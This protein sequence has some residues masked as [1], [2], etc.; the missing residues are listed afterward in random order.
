VFDGPPLKQSEDLFVAWMTL[1]EGV[2]APIDAEFREIFDL[3]CEKGFRAIQDEAAF[4]FRLDPGSL[5]AFVAKLADLPGHFERAMATFLDHPD[6]WAGAM[7]FFHA[8]SLTYWRKRGGF[9]KKPAALDRASRDDL[10]RSIGTWFHET[11]GRGHHCKVEALRRDERDY[12]FAYP[13]DYG[14]QTLEWEAGQFQRR[15]HQPAFEVVFLWSE[16]DGT[17]DI[18]HAGAT[19]AIEPLQG[20]FAR[21]ILKIDE[22]PPDPKDKRVYDLEPLRRRSFQFVYA[23]DSGIRSVAV[24]KLRLAARAPKGHRIVFEADP[25]ENRL[26]LY[27][28]LEDAAKSVALA[29]WNVTQ[30]EITAKVQMAP[31]KPV[32]TETFRVTWPNACTLRYDESGLKVRAMLQASGIEPRETLV[33]LLDEIL[34]RVG[35]APDGVAFVGQSELPAWPAREVDILKEQGLLA[36]AAPAESAV[37][38]GCERQCTMPVQVLPSAGAGF[39]VCDKRPDI[40]RVAVPLDRLQRWQASGNAIAAVLARFLTLRPAEALA[41]HRRWPVGL[42]KRGT[43]AGPLVLTAGE[44]LTLALAGHALS[45]ADILVWRRGRLEVQRQR[46]M[47]CLANPVPGASGLETPAQRRDRLMKRRD[48]LQA[49]GE[50]NFLKILAEEEGFAGTSRVKQ[51]LY[52][53]KTSSASQG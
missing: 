43:R 27:D 4:Q 16:R 19:T 3:S 32:K 37:C 17:L 48:A 45:L 7:Q 50:R 49:S 21:T 24:R 15:A 46:L 8:D 10:E 38:P 31:D 52:P 28:L 34:A 1:T 11:E 14:Q 41:T 40:N 33:P 35:A 13:A 51:L 53:K 29:V 2:R 39:I 6:F 30:A 44:G 26:G 23:P 12:F 36:A 5:K 20:I 42:M 47:D 22:L 9:P 18:H 25:S